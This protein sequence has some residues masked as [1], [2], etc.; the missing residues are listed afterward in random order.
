MTKEQLRTQKIN[1]GWQVPEVSE[2]QLVSAQ[3]LEPK[4]Y[5]VNNVF[6]P[7]RESYGTAT[8]V[9]Y[10]EGTENEKAVGQ[11]EWKTDFR[12]ELNTFVRGMETGAVWGITV[13]RV[14][15]QDLMAEVE[16]IIESA[17]KGSRKTY[18]VRKRNGNFEFIEIV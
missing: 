17:G 3:G 7:E 6:N 8:V 4:K 13:L 14:H 11:N 18:F 5:D 9:V 1:E 15:E 12:D 16:A 2:W 10:N